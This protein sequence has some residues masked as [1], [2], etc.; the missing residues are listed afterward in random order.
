MYVFR[1]EPHNNKIL[2]LLSMT[3]HDVT[4]SAKSY[5]TFVL[6]ASADLHENLLPLK[7]HTRSFIMI[8]LTDGNV[9]HLNIR[10]I[11]P[12]DSDNALHTINI[13]HCI[14]VC[15]TQPYRGG[16]LGDM[17]WRAVMSGVVCL[18]RVLRFQSLCHRYDCMFDVRMRAFAFNSFAFLLCFRPSVLF[19]GF[20]FVSFP[21]CFVSCLARCCST[22]LGSS[23]LP[24]F[25]Q[26]ILL[27]W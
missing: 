6:V 13:Q 26:S 9:T 10:H 17:L 7:L 27:L 14:N 2:W 5:S 4:L 21:V 19:R 24:S 8:P 16:I 20:Y 1:Y 18:R 15:E 11:T 12:R 25:N 22:S 23:L 3:W